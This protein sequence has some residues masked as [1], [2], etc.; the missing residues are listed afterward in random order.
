V[1]NGKTG[2]VIDGI[3]ICSGAKGKGEKNKNNRSLPLL[4]QRTEN[5]SPVQKEEMFIDQRT[6]E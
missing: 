3:P 5:S 4:E 1:K 2:R 6:M